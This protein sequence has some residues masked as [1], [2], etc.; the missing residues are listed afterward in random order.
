MILAGN[1]LNNVYSR[2]LM[3]YDS[4]FSSGGE[5]VQCHAATLRTVIVSGAEGSATGWDLQPSVEGTFL[6]LL[7][8]RVNSHI[9][10][11]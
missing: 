2:N 4:L 10:L 8:S 7:L 1:A 5:R 3:F 9:I 6:A 11:P